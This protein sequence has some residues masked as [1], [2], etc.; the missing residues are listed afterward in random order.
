MT[1]ILLADPDP[2]ARKA[3]ALLINHKL[4]LED[5]HEVADSQSLLRQMTECQ[6]DVLLVDSSLLAPLSQ[7]EKQSL[8]VNR[9]DLRLFVLSINLEEAAQAQSL[10]GVFIHKG[11]P[12]AQVLKHLKAWLQNKPGIDKV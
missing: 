5:I 12:G 9:P 10:G 7:A 11:S 4:G 6:P 1:R 3:L 8:I 2:S